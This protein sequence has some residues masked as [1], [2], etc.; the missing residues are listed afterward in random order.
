MKILFLDV[1]GVLNIMGA[2]YNSH[3]YTN[4]GNDPIE[5]HLMVRLEFLLE[6]IP[7]LYIVISSSWLEPQLK[8]KLAKYRFKYTDRMIGRTPR[9]KHTRGE[10]IA[11]WLHEHTDISDYIVI[12]DEI[13]DICGS[14]SSAIDITKVVEIDMGEGL[15]NKNVLDIIT[16]LNNLEQYIYTEHLA[17]DENVKKFIG[18]GYRPHVIIDKLEKFSSFKI[19]NKNL[20]MHMQRKNN[21]IS[22]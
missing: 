10:Q 3:S 17:T 16:K 15:S 4:L 20:L 2:S 22:I 14:K 18:L 9:G 13:D 19:D 6:R 5:K 11:D 12:D 21:E 8:L 7:D 1:D